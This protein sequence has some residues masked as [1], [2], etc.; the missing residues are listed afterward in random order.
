MASTSYYTVALT[1]HPDS[2]G[3]GD[4]DIEAH[5]SWVSTE[6]ISLS[7]RLSGN[8]K[9]LRIPT[10]GPVR[11]A[12]GLWQHTCFEAFV[13]LKGGPEYWEFNFSPS[14]QW[15]VYYFRA[16]RGGGPL[17]DAELAPNIAARSANDC[18]DLDATIH[19]DC[20]PVISQN[21]TLRVGLSAVIED[22]KGTLSYWALRH[23]PGKP[24]FHHPDGL[25]LEIEQPT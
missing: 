14:G 12:D 1:R 23:P 7:Y 21:R 10:L 3:A 20:L 4:Y 24:D 17:K 19:L 13:S 6:K 25:A 11:R 5:V 2:Q 15:A 22:E 8:I 9:Q 16:Y 18:L